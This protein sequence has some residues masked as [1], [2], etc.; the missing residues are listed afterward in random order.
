[1]SVSFFACLLYLVQVVVR[2]LYLVQVVV[3]L[4]YLVQVVVG[5]FVISCSGGCMRESLGR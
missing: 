5:V 2:L 3:R 1:M 4:L